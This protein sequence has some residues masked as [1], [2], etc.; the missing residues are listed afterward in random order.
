M[1]G[2]DLNVLDVTCI[3][4]FY[5]LNTRWGQ[6][7]F[8]PIQDPREIHW[9]DELTRAV[10]RCRMKARSSFIDI[11]L[12]WVNVVYEFV[13][14]LSSNC[15]MTSKIVIN[16]SWV[17]FIKIVGEKP[18]VKRIGRVPTTKERCWPDVGRASVCT[19]QYRIGIPT[20][21]YG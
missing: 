5:E 3:R 7:V 6:A 2:T 12:L 11:K 21:V 8:Q 10:R 15:S 1:R 20:L 4:R 19:E 16:R 13:A 18:A 17:C 9:W 14:Y